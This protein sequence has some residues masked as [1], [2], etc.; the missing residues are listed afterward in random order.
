MILG[1]NSAIWLLGIGLVLIGLCH[2]PVSYYARVGFLV[3]AAITLALIRADSF[4]I[5]GMKEAW[6]APWSPAIWANFGLDVH[7][8][9]DRLP[10][11]RKS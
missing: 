7:V 8:S 9:I 10:V 1:F 4:A 5:P 3:A 11:R 2:L 6:K